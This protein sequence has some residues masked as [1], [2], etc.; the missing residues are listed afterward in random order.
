MLSRSSVIARSGRRARRAASPGPRP[1][2][3]RRSIVVAARVLA[4][5][6]FA[7]LGLLEALLGFG[8]LVRRQ[9]ALAA[10]G[11]V[12]LKRGGA[13]GRGAGG[14][15]EDRTCRLLRWARLPAT[16]VPGHGRPGWLAARG[17]TSR[18]LR[19][20]PTPS[21]APSTLTP[22]ALPRPAATR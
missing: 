21:T 19:T 3:G 12:G 18:P 22:A 15:V 4:G 8:F 17:P 1:S 13:R 9:L 6:A 11:L 16:P 14:G 7:G 20:P 10:G 5:Q 2:P